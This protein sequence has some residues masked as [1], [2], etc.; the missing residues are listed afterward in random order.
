MG[1]SER[2]TTERLSH[3]R[4]RRFCFQ[5]L[6]VICVTLVFCYTMSSNSL[7]WW[8]N[9]PIQ[10]HYQWFF[11]QT[12]QAYEPPPF[13]IL[14]KHKANS[15]RVHNTTVQTTTISI[16]TVQTTIVEHQTVQTTTQIAPTEPPIQCNPSYARNYRF[17]ID[18]RD[19]CKNH[20]PF[21]VLMV[22]VS[23]H[24]VIA[25]DV[26]RQTWGKERLV[27]GKVVVT[28][29]ML[30]LSNRIDASKLEEENLQHHD[31]IQSNFMDTYLNLTIKTMV[32]MDWLATHCS[33]AE[34]AMKIDSDMFLNIDNLL[35]MLQ[36]PGIPKVNYLTGYLMKNRPVVR[37]KSSKWY[38]SEELFPD[39]IYPNYALGMGYV[40]SVDLAEKLVNAS[41]SVKYFNNEDAYVGACMKSL[42]LKPTSPPNPSQFGIYNSNFDRCRY[43]RTITFILSSPQQLRKY[44]NNMKKP[45]PP[46][47]NE[48]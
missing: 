46:C 8:E 22:P 15:S 30:G 17:L 7:E 42:G 10:K 48:H 34:Y 25:R 43:L 27:Q 32:I 14:S 23:T 20:S 16:T 5:L 40:F 11:N 12:N 47:H 19:I 1:E 33:T 4:K 18:N 2:S 39:P 36:K 24:D 41:K 38:V 31:L 26:I 6:L 13:R 37:T 45:G 3:Q 44:W 35:I 28:L 9:S 29:F 21:L